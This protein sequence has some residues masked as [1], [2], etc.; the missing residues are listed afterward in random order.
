MTFVKDTFLKFIIFK[1]KHTFETNLLK[2]VYQFHQFQV[3]LKNKIMK[4]LS[5]FEKEWCIFDIYK[6]DV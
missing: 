6:K 5:N 3:C 4:I 1:V 2:C